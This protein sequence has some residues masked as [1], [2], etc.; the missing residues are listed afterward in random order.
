MVLPLLREKPAITS[1]G[2][3]TQ[4]PVS[5]GSLAGP[6][7]VPPGRGGSANHGRSSQRPLLRA[8]SSLTT[9]RP[10]QA[11]ELSRLTG[12]GSAT[13]APTPGGEQPRRQDLPVTDGRPRPPPA[14]P[15]SPGH[16]TR[17]CTSDPTPA[18]LSHRHRRR[19]P[20]PSPQACSRGTLPLYPGTKSAQIP[21]CSEP[22]SSWSSGPI[23]LVLRARQVATRRRARRPVR[24]ERGPS[25]AR[26][27]APWVLAVGGAG[28]GGGA[29]RWAAARRG[30]AR[31]P[32]APPRGGEGE[33][34]GARG[35]RRAAAWRGPCPLHLRGRPRGPGPTLVSEPP[36]FGSS[37]WN[38]T[39][40]R[41]KPCHPPPWMQPD[42]DQ[43]LFKR[44]LFAEKRARQHGSR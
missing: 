37:F 3:R 10:P 25:G 36:W 38:Q 22:Q 34:D 24:P 43:S 33:R 28:G 17:G 2:P 30:F 14:L 4:D 39:P 7:Q 11:T 15:P 21:G 8:P 5:K 18:S 23:H 42:R 44:W 1:A 13:P 9:A 27:A 12:T 35:G 19:A 29:K 26:R 40:V 41:R 20:P 16:C 31:A 32:G 6:L